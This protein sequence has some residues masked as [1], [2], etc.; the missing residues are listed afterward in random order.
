MLKSQVSASLDKFRGVTATVTPFWLLSC[1]ASSTAAAGK[2]Q[3]AANSDA[4]IANCHLRIT[5]FLMKDSGNAGESEY[6]V[7]P[8]L[9]GR[10]RVQGGVPFVARAGAGDAVC[11]IV[12]LPDCDV[13]ASRRPGEERT[14]ACDAHVSP[15]AWDRPGMAEPA[16]TEVKDDDKIKFSADS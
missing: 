3:L 15:V 13:R 5:V 6:Y 11:L 4:V 2:K 9:G 12:V 14:P 8:M 7:T 16:V 1:V 10:I